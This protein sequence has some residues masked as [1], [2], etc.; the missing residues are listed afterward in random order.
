MLKK[1]E[2]TLKAGEEAVHFNLNKSLKQYDY[3]NT[4]CKIIE[5]I[6]PISLELIFGCN[7]QNSVNENEM[8]F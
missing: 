8:N 5:T 2:L 7:F 3:E 6:V 4:D 1:R